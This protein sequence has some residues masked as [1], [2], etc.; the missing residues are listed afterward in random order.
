MLVAS[1][2]ETCGPVI[3]AVAVDT[4]RCSPSPGHPGAG[5]VGGVSDGGG[6]TTS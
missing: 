2:V 5:N 6:T 3:S 1:R 4:P